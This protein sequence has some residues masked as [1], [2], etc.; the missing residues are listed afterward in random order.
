MKQVTITYDGDAIKC[1][2]EKS[3]LDNLLDQGLAVDHSCKKGSCLTCL[4]KTS[5]DVDPKSRAPL[6]PTQVEQ[7]YF[8]GCQQMPAHGM[9]VNAAVGEELFIKARIISSKHLMGHVFRIRLEPLEDF[10]FKPGQFL[11]VKGP[12]GEVRSYSIA[13]LPQDPSIE[14]H[15]T[16]HK[17]G[18]VSRWLCDPSRIDEEI[19]ISGSYGDCFYLKGNPTQNLLL[20]GT[21]TGLAPLL[22]VLRDALQHGHTGDIDLYHGAV[23]GDGFYMRNNLAKLENE[24]PNVKVNYSTLQDTGDDSIPTTPIQDLAFGNHPSLK[25]WRVYLC[26]D[27]DMVKKTKTKAYLADAKLSDIFADPFDLATA[28]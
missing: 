9:A 24:Y 6:K 2:P 13:S 25:D 20:I 19:E 27:P 21:S 10:D 12:G 8:L 1:D 14:L 4:M 17:H 28:K 22:G 18:I 16:E 5:D 23:N 7:G 26:G 11:N 3:V 15:V